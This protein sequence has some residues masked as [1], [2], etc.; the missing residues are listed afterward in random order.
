M[1]EIKFE[2]DMDGSVNRLEIVSSG[3]FEFDNELVRVGKKM[4]RWIPALQN[5]INIPVNYVHPIIFNGVD[6]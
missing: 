1:V 3:G 2:V 4:P 6:E 5:G